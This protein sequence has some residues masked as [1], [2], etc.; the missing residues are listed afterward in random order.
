MRLVESDRNLW[1]DGDHHT[2]D[3]TDELLYRRARLLAHKREV[4]FSSV[5]QIITLRTANATDRDPDQILLPISPVRISYNF[6]RSCRLL[7]SDESFD[8]MMHS[9]FG[10]LVL[11]RLGP[12][13]GHC[14][15]SL[16]QFGSPSATELVQ[17]AG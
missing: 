7:E 2:G 1:M 4:H 14:S 16:Q 8:V 5:I 13:Y 3:A 11:D 10:R 15:E 6:L 9:L 12:L 17:P